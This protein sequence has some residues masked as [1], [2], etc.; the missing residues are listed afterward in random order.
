MEGRIRNWCD[1][2]KISLR[3]CLAGSGCRIS[4]GELLEKIPKPL[5]YYYEN[6]D[7]DEIFNRYVYLDKI[8]GGKPSFVF[9][10]PSY[11]NIDWVYLNLGSVFKQRYVN[12]RVIYIDDC[13]RDGTFL[14]VK[15]IVTRYGMWGKFRLCRQPVRNYQS[16]SR[17][18]AY[19]LCDDDEILCM[20]DGD[21]W[22]SNPLVLNKLVDLY[23]RG[24][25]VTYG[26]YQ[27]Y[28]GMG[29]ENG[30]Y[31][32]EIFPKE[33]IEKRGFRHYRWTSCHFRTGYAGLFKKIKLGDML[34]KKNQFI[35]CCTDLCEMYSVLEMASP[36]IARCPESLYIYNRMASE[37]NS[38]S[39]YNQNKN[40]I[41]KL[42]RNYVIKKIETTLKYPVIDRG[43]L[44]RNMNIEIDPNLYWISPKIKE[45][46]VR[47]LL[48]L[49]TIT[50]LNYL[51]R[52]L[53]IEN[54]LVLYD[55]N[56]KIG[57]LLNLSD[58]VYI[59]RRDF[60]IK[61]GDLVISVDNLDID[62]WD[63]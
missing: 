7:K 5:H 36:Y 53:E 61:L 31:G 24:A 23:T 35:R 22:L 18:S 14:E 58:M 6:K 10:I 40:P 56:I 55:R 43:I 2:N 62:L 29:I 27:F 45:S 11:N 39:Y 4:Y 17:F 41:E 1:R 48:K 19:H 63:K 12:Y 57:N 3:Q 50:S 52:D 47:K 8:L 15:K 26:S 32:N 16:G 13:S 25:M 38:N 37:L 33:I 28:R 42:Y 30:I 20:L 44:F 54:G 49:L 9:I 34:D 21:D 59:K 60:E 51:G 46:N